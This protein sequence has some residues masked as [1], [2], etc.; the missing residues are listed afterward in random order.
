ML[1]TILSIAV[2]LL[3]AY[4][5]TMLIQRF[6]DNERL[7]GKLHLI[8]LKSLVS[9]GI[10]IAAIIISLSSLSTFSRGWETLVAGS[11]IMAVVLG[12]AAQETL[13][14]VF[15]G[16]AMSS[17]RSRPFDIGDRVKI[18]DAEPGYVKD[19]TLR[20][21]V[22]VTYLNSTIVIPNSVVGK[23]MITNYTSQDAC[24]Y[25]I[26]IYVSYTSDIPR[27]MEIM[28]DV[29]LTHPLHYGEDNVK[30]LC[31]ECGDSGVLLKGV[32]TTK[33]FSDNAAACSDCLLEIMRRFNEED[34]SIPY[35]K[36]E[37]IQKDI[38]QR[39]V[40]EPEV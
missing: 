6:L 10:W 13:G 22:I 14:N 1:T 5:I 11:G 35:T 17:V 9:V 29:I 20:H 23:S 15:S 39:I 3:C 24:G 7:H 28:K 4:V 16:I 18:G 19:I 37:V 2:P 38:K 25:P 26:D 40:K 31:K 33:D 8:L 32:V 27:A 12:L 36:I 21:V 34:I 30:I